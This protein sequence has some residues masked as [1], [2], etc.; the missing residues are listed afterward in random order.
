MQYTIKN[1]KV[2]VSVESKGAELK[3][4]KFNDVDYLHNGQQPYWNRTAPILW[5]NVGAIKDGYTIINGEKYRL[6]KHG[7]LRDSEFV[8]VSHDNTSLT[9]KLVSNEQ[10]KELYPFDFEIIIVYRIVDSTVESS[11][12]INNKSTKTMPFNLGLHPAFK[13]PHSSD[14]QFEDYKIKFGVTGTYEMPTVNLS[15]G[16]ID[17]TK[18]NRTFTNFNTLSLNYDDYKNDALIFE[19][20]L[21]RSVCLQNK[22]GSHGIN[23]SFEDFPMLGIWTPD[24]IKSPFICIEP[25][26]GCGD[27]IDHD[28][29]FT[30]KR[31]II[32]LLP[33]DSKTITYKLELF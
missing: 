29:I 3:V 23:F 27:P 19:N 33:N 30:N 2:T 10:T 25:W 8:V 32:N 6:P 5:P 21:K 24:S 17:F 15:N 1:E 28:H 9:L 12:S 14:E 22:D 4:I 13:V 31:D 11:I 26:I 18:R 20:I 16:T 7:F